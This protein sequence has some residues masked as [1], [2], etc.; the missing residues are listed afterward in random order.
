MCKKG[1]TFKILEKG[2]RTVKTSIQSPNPT[3]TGACGS[4]DCVACRG[5]HKTHSVGNP[6]C[7]TSVHAICARQTIQ[8]LT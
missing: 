7:S 2:G 8:V 3:A 1:L 5:G 6:M 4:Q